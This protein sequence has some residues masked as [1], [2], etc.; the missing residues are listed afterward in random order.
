MCNDAH[1][2]SDET[3]SGLDKSVGTACAANQGATR[4]RAQ[5][6][7]STLIPRYVLSR[8]WPPMLRRTARVRRDSGDRETHHPTVRS[9]G[10][11]TANIPREHRAATSCAGLSS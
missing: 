3:R 4:V 5:F 1:Q 8:W 9:P 2:H 7:S 11:A 6:G 10:H